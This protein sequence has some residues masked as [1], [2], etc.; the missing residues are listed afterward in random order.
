MSDRNYGHVKI[1]LLVDSEF[2]QQHI[3]F[4]LQYCNV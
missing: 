2:N 1:I 4:G 3:E